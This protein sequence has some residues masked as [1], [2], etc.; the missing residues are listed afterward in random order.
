MTIRES[1]FPRFESE[2]Y[3]KELAQISHRQTTTQ[4]RTPATATRIVGILFA[5][6]GFD[7]GD[8]LSRNECGGT[9][10]YK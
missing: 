9:A 2:T 8:D 4:F 6:F 10:C 1:S 5:A 7:I 3:C